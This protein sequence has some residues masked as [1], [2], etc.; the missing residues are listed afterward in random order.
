[1]VRRPGAADGR[2]EARACI[3]HLQ[4]AAHEDVADHPAGLPGGRGAGHGNPGVFV[5]RTEPLSKGRQR[6]ALG[7]VVEVASEHDR[8]GIPEP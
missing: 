8:T 6:R 7:T 5:G 2:V 4:R 1:M 3:D